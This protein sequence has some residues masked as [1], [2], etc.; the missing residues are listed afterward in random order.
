MLFVLTKA[1]GRNRLL[2]SAVR[3][4]RLHGALNSILYRERGGELADR[5]SHWGIDTKTNL[6]A[7]GIVS[8][9]VVS[10]V[11]FLI[12]SHFREPLAAVSIV[13]HSSGACKLVWRTYTLLFLYVH[14]AV[15]IYF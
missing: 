7:G 3:I 11:L 14:E 6:R 12:I 1:S 5:C 10:I 15:C 4:F 9:K 2:E 8:T 13:K